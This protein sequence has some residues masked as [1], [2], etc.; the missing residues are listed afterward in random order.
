MRLLTAAEAAAQA[1]ISVQLLKQQIADGTGPA[2][3]RLGRGHS[4]IFVPQDALEEWIR[5]RTTPA[6]RVPQLS[7]GT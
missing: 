7:E 4:R 1:R 5:Q 6:P 2:V 3:T